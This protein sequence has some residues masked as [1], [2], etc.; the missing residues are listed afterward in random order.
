MTSSRLAGGRRRR[1]ARPAA[2]IRLGS[3]RRRGRGHHAL[4]RASAPARRARR[5]AGLPARSRTTLAARLRRGLGAGVAAPPCRRRGAAWRGRA[6]RRRVRRR[7]RRAIDHVAADQDADERDGDLGGGLETG[8]IGRRRGRRARRRRGQ[9]HAVDRLPAAA[10]Q[11]PGARRAGRT[12]DRR[13]SASTMSGVS[14]LR[15][16]PDIKLEQRRPDRVML[17][18]EGELAPA[19][20]LARG[21]GRAGRRIGRAGARP[22]RPA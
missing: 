20:V 16:D 14:H 17:L 2:P 11:W 7:E 9:R 8:G 19:V 10:R 22:R 12:P 1:A 6:G 13:G 15:E 3:L 5:A 18:V 4:E 21:G